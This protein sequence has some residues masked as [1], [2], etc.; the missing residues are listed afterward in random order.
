MRPL[1]YEAIILADSINEF[2]NRLTTMKIT[3]PRF[4]LAQLNTHRIFSKN[5]ASSRAVPVSRVIQTVIDSPFIPTFATN[6]AGMQAGQA[7]SPVRHALAIGLWKLGVYTS[8]GIS[9][10]LSKLGVHKQ[11][12]NRPLEPYAWETV[13]VSST[14]WSNFFKQRLDG[15]AQPEM[16]TIA[17]LMY[18]AMQASTPQMMRAGEWHLPYIQPH[19]RICFTI[20]EQICISTARVARV[21]YARHEEFFSL[22]KDI[23]RHDDMLRLGHMSPFEHVAQAWTA[24]DRKGN[25]IGWQQY[26]KL[27]QPEDVTLE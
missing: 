25:F 21:S 24:P 1:T 14:G 8:V 20:K 13:I 27:V 4:I 2:G 18:E 15:H 5:A 9:Y 12:S 17:R 6:R 16:Q 3:L 22:K 10:L 23:A 19:E 11:W 7:L 26:R